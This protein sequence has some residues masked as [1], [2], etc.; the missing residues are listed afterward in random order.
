MAIQIQISNKQQLALQALNDSTHTEILYGGSAGGGKTYLGCIWVTTMCLKYPG[1]RFMIARD[2]L[3]T[4]KK[5]SIVTL[6]SKVFPLFEL[7][8]DKAYKYN[9][10]EGSIKFI[11]GSEIMLGYLKF[12]PSDPNFDRLGSLEITGAWIDEGSEISSTGYEILKTRIRHNLDKNNLIPKILVTTNPCDNFLKTDFWLPYSKGIENDKKMFISATMNDNPYL[13]SSYADVLN[14]IKDP[15]HRKRLR[16]GDWNFTESPDTLFNSSIINNAVVELEKGDGIGCVG[17]DIAREGDDKTILSYIKN[18]TLVQ[19]QEIQI[20]K[21]SIDI[22]SQIA[23]KIIEFCKTNN[24]GYEHV[25]IDSVGVGAGVLDSLHRLSFFVKS[26]KGGNEPTDK[27]SFINLRAEA[28]WQ[29]K[30][31]LTDNLKIYRNIYGFDELSMELR[32]IKYSNNDKKIIIESKKDIK[33]RLG[34]SPDFADSFKIANW[35]RKSK[36]ENMGLGFVI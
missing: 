17:V 18:N 31:D 9:M 19:I 23:K 36:N 20:D 32:Q 6:I 30:Q 15:T 13:E 3:T 4:L 11:N 12:E 35:V 33:K 16:D 22:S 29:L 26:F 10:N 25:A 28:Y 5:T 8:A 34:K 14:S 27:T 21:Q 7:K 2:D 1:T 24:V